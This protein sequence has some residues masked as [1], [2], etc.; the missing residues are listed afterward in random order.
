MP[1][2][3]RWLGLAGERAPEE[4]RRR[5]ALL[6]GFV[7]AHEELERLQEAG[8]LPRAER[9]HLERPI[10]EQEAV[11]LEGMAPVAEEPA[12]GQEEQLAERIG[13]LVAQRRRIQALRGAGALAD[14]AAGDLV[15]EIDRRIAVLGERLA[16]ER[17]AGAH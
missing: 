1:W 11:L 15:D 5:E 12:E 14:A 6:Q 13:A 8:T 17:D 7:V 16:C 9:R 2:L 10:E 3:A 4:T